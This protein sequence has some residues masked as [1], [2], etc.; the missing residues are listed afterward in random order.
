MACGKNCDHKTEI[1]DAEDKLRSEAL[2]LFLDD[3]GVPTNREQAKCGLVFSDEATTKSLTQGLNEKGEVSLWKLG[4]CHAGVT[5]WEW[6]L[7]T[8]EI[9]ID[10]L[11]EGP[12]LCYDSLERNTWDGIAHED[13]RKRVM[14]AVQRF[15]ETGYVSFD[16]SFRLATEIPRWV[17]ARDMQLV[18]DAN[19]EP[20]QVIGI[21]VDITESQIAKNCA[22][23]G[24][25]L[26]ESDSEDRINWHRL[27]SELDHHYVD[28]D[29]IDEIRHQFDSMFNSLMMIG[30]IP[31]FRKDADLAYV[32]V[33]RPFETLVGLSWQEIL[34]RS[35]EELW[36]RKQVSIY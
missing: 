35:D 11:A 6:D 9:K 23:W 12:P 5:M 32:D 31:A 17:H 7:K 28:G 25:D 15:E 8:R 24:K 13:D 1:S 10:E 18:L 33:N 34:K 3:S 22:C 21:F 19:D 30:D 26:P 2:I 4:M 36:G 20:L 14:E 27:I 16:C 29:R